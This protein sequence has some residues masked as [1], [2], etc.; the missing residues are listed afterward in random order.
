MGIFNSD[1][2]SDD[3]L[4]NVL[5]EQYERKEK[6]TIPYHEAKGIIEK[7][8][9]K[10]CDKFGGTE[11]PELRI[12]KEKDETN[13]R[14]DFSKDADPYEIVKIFSGKIGDLRLNNSLSSVVLS[15]DDTRIF[16]HENGYMGNSINI[17]KKDDFTAQEIDA[18]V[19]TYIAGNRQKDKVIS[20]EEKLENLGVTI[21]DSEEGLTWDYIAGYDHVKQEIKDTVILPLKNPEIYETIA[22]GTRK[23]YESVR[24]KAVLFEGPPGTGKTTSARIIANE[25]ESSMIYVPVESIMTKWYGE[26][27]RNLS[28]IF[29][30]AQD[31]GDSIIFLDE[32]D[33]LATSRER[34]LHEASRRVLSVLLRK[35][36][37]FE[38]NDNTLLIGATNRKDD[39]DPALISRFD[40][41]VNFPLPNLE[42]R[43]GI[44]QSYAKQLDESELKRLAESSEGVS[45]RNIKDICEHSERRWASKRIRGLVEDDLPAFDE[46]IHSLEARMDGGI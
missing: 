20:P 21:F 11:F 18:I 33:S 40:L 12:E 38:P 32:I 16:L 35:I 23:R 45:G 34:D 46:Y 9:S 17:T 44:F 2:K 19:E 29:S 22:R 24:P 31:L 42:E 5:S 30:S 43:V 3:G 15:K 4:E 28:E 1:D 25:A 41:N 27:E 13:V 6:S 8:I 36:D 26:S 37:G 39:L 14:Y 10:Y 7:N